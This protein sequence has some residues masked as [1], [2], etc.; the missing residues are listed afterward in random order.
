MKIRFW[1]VRG[2]IPCP[3]PNTVK[4]GGNTVCIE[5]RIKETDR[6]I[7][8]DAGSG[9]RELGNFML[10]HDLPKGPINTEIYLTHTHWD[11]IM[12]FPFFTPIYIPK[13]KLKIYGPVSYEQDTLEKIVGGQLTYRYFPVREAELGAEIKYIQLKEGSFDLG[14]GITLTT[15]YLNHPILCLGYRFEYRGKV[16]CTSYDTEP[17]QNLFSTDPK[18]PSYDEAIAEEGDMVAKEQNKIAEDFFAGADLLIYDTQYT[19][20]EY[21]SSKL[22][23]GHSSFEY[24]IAAANRAG[25]KSMAFF[26]HEPMRTDEQMDELAKL[27]CE[28]DKFGPTKIFFAREG[29]EIEL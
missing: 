20:E 6:L 9:I 27:F 5:L 4:Y 16:F 2:S 12:G 18:D 10:G 11:H 17:F 24:A 25:V 19:Q 15:K 7:I 1:G 13:T 21:E 8:I 14:D 26:H 23:W 28:P 22:G 29:M 3:G